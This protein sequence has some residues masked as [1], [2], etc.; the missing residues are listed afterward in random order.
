MTNLNQ[1]LTVRCL[2]E[3][4]RAAHEAEL[5]Q[6]AQTILLQDA[7]VFIPRRHLPGAD[8]FEDLEI[9]NLF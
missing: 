4:T 5:S 8:P 7:M 6:V 1:D 3:Q 9:L 2:G